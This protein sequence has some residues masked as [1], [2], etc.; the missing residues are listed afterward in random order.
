[1]QNDGNFIVFYRVVYVLIVC[2]FGGKVFFN[3]ITGGFMEYFNY[4]TIQLLGETQGS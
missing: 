3:G 1:M 4:S 2:L